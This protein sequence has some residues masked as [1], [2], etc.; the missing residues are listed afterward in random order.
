MNSLQT[1]KLESLSLWLADFSDLGVTLFAQ[2][3]GSVALEV[4]EASSASFGGGLLTSISLLIVSDE[5]LADAVGVSLRDGSVSLF[6]VSKEDDVVDWDNLA[7]D[8][9]AL[10]LYSLDVE[11][12]CDD[13]KFAGEFTKFNGDE[14]TKFNEACVDHDKRSEV[15]IFRNEAAT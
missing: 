1:K 10:D 6:D 13:S 7:W 15:E 3:E 4:I 5:G 9:R 8:V 12:V 14:A 2:S 11:D